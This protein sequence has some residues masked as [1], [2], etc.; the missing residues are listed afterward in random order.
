MSPVK[1]TAYAK[2][3]R[4]E[5]GGAEVVREWRVEPQGSGFRGE[6]GWW[7]RKHG[8]CSYTEELGQWPM[9]SVQSW[10]MATSAS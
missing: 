4:K 3:W 7:Q 8:P 2:A 10:H 9:G 1:G 5:R 6:G